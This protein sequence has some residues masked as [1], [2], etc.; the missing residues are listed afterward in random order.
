MTDTHEP[1]DRPEPEPEQRLPVPRPPAEVA[2]VERF[3][4]PPSTRAVELTPERA[5]AGRAPVVQR[6]LGRLPRASSSSCSSPSTSSTSSAPLGLTRAAAR[7][8]GRS[9]QVTRGRAR[10]QPVRGELRALPRRDSWRGRDRAGPQP[11]GQAVRPP[12]RATTCNNVLDRR[13][14]V[15]LRQ[16]ELA[17][18]GLVERATTAGP[19][20]YHPDRRPDR[21]H[22]RAQRRRVH[23]SA[24]RSSFEPMVDPITGEV[25]DV[26]R[27]AATRTTSRQ[28][29]ATPYP[30]CWTDA[31]ATAVRLARPPSGSPAASGSPGPPTPTRT[32]VNLDGRR[33]SSSTR[34]SSTARPTRPFVI[35]FDNQ[36]AGDPHNVEIKDSTGA[37]RVH[38]R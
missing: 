4:S 23:R 37:G 36:D 2:P 13:R 9:Q 18:A 22:P 24:T 1:S 17:D 34:P 15:R 14:P 35:E 19:L 29:G 27:L 12:Q 3:T 33:A 28:P 21:V 26:H 6:A 11:P 5:A 25:R 7:G 30:A 8:R 31:F 10:L 16:P 38:G 32:V 20:N